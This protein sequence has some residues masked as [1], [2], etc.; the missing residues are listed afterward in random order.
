MLIIRAYTYVCIAYIWK[1]TR[2]S[3]KHMLLSANFEMKIELTSHTTNAILNCS[4]I[5]MRRRLLLLQYKW[6]QPECYLMSLI[7]TFQFNWNSLQYI[8]D[9]YVSANA[10][11]SSEIMLCKI[12]TRVLAIS[13]LFGPIHVEPLTKPN[14]HTRL[15]LLY[16]CRVARSHFAPHYKVV[17]TNANCSVSCTHLLFFTFSHTSSNVFFMV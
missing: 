9:I 4:R 8:V 15:P 10:H 12:N 1:S 13:S 2:V 17:I 7:Y 5:M 3:C 11:T 16:L 6:N 14:T